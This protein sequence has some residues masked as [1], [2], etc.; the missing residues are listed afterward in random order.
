MLSEVWKDVVGY[1]KLYEVSSYG[2]VRRK[3]Q[4]HSYDKRRLTFRYNKHD[5]HQRVKL[6]NRGTK[7]LFF[8]HRLVSTAF[9]GPIPKGYEVN[10]LDGNPENNRIDNL[11]YVTRS[12]NRK[13]ATRVLG[14]GVLNGEVISK[15]KEYLTEGRTQ[16]N[17]AN[18]LGVGQT[19]VSKISRGVHWSQNNVPT[20]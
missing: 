6:S 17:I 11:E 13:H 19:V 14:K 8:V 2:I 15:I 9:L 3:V 10:H 1:E 20:T 5:K 4:Y 16:E 7:K 18:L 12:Q